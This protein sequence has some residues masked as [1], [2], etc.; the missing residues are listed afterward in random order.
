MMRERLRLAFPRTLLVAPLV[1][2]LVALLARS[3]LLALFPLP[4]PWVA[5]GVALA[6][7]PAVLARGSPLPHLLL[8]VVPVLAVASYDQSRLDWLRVLKDFGVASPGFPDLLRVGMGLGALSLAWAT[9]AVDASLRI[10]HAAT[11]RGVDA[12]DA[13]AAS[14]VV[15]ARSGTVFAGAFLGTIAV[16]ALALLATLLDVSSLLGGRASFLAPLVAVGLVALA[17]VLLWRERATS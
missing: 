16:G 9:H 14:R 11:E 15:R 2:L 3:S 12:T 6:L 8:A 13:R 5:A 1:A 17:A 7:V 10:R 4:G